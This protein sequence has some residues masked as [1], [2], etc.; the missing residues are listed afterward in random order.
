MRFPLQDVRG[1][2]RRVWQSNWERSQKEFSL[3]QALFTTGIRGKRNIKNKWKRQNDRAVCENTC[4]TH[5]NTTHVNM[6][7]FTLESLLHPTHHPA[8][9]HLWP[10]LK[11][12]S[13]SQN[14]QSNMNNKIIISP[15]LHT[16]N[17]QRTCGNLYSAG[18]SSLPQSS[19]CNYCAIKP[20]R[21]CNDWLR[22]WHWAGTVTQSPQL[23]RHSKIAVFLSEPELNLKW[24]LDKKKKKKKDSNSEFNIALSGS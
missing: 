4:L 13:K 3:F 6:Q 18:C 1:R 20:L 21:Q 10:Q 9:K 14:T 15:T 12:V 7:A 19:L 5:T 22:C 24:I 16:H 11:K 2:G 23:I 17:H 8:A